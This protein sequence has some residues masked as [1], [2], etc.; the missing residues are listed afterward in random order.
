MDS[1]RKTA[2]IVGVLF[3]I[4]TVTAILTIA[5]LGST[6]EKPLNFA[7]VSANEFQVVMAVIF[8]LIL[9]VSVTGIGV[10]MFPIL[11]KHNEGLALGYV[12]FRHTEAICIIIAS[13]SILSL[14]TISKEFVGE[15][16]RAH[17]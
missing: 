5:F 14:L 4:A 17:V 7:N 16:G 6:L 10:L 8:W 11:K 15:I 3:I 1:Y 12:G 13:I 9:A 2:M